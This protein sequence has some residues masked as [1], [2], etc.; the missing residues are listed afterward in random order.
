MTHARKILANYSFLSAGD[1]ISRVLAFWAMIRIAGILGK[2]LFG[3]L[4]V[5]AAPMIAMRL[6][7]RGRG[8]LPD[9]LMIYNR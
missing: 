8:D 6:P 9:G 7:R 3:I 1:L 4:G 2:D 5:A